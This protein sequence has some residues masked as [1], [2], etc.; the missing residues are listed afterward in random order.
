MDCVGQELMGIGV[1]SLAAFLFALV[2]GSSA[3]AACTLPY[4]FIDNTIAYSAQIDAN[5]AAVADCTGGGGAVGGNPT[6]T[7]SDVAVNGAAA[8]FMRSDA[9]PAIQKASAS[10]FGIVEVDGTTITSSGGVITAT[11]GGSGCTISGAAG[12]VFNTGS[13]TCTTDAAITAT[14]GALSLGSSGTA[15]S[16]AFGNATS[17]TITLQ[18]VT[19]A[20]GSSVLSL[21]IAT[22]TLVGKATIDTLTNKT[23]TSPTMTAPVLGTPASGVATNLTGTAAGLTAGTVT[24]NANLTGPI[25]STGNA[26]AI[27]SQTG[28]GTKFVVDTSPTLVTPILGIATA[29]SVNKVALTAPATSATLTIADGKTLTDTSGTGAVALK[30]AT[31]GGFAQ[32]ACADLSNGATGCSTTVGTMATQAASAVAI[33]GGTAAGLTGL[34]IRD[35]SAAFDVTIAGTSSTALSAG[36]VLTLDMKNVAHTLAF[37]STANTITFPSA[38]SYT[39]FGTND[40]SGN[41]TTAV[42]TT[43]T[44]T[45]GDCV[46]IDANGNHIANGSACGSGGGT[47]LAITVQTFSASGTYTPAAGLIYAIAECVGDGGGGGG[48]AANATGNS[49]GGGG[50]AGSYS[51]VRLTAAQI[52]ASQA[53]TIPTAAAGGATGNNAGANGGDVSL[54]TLCVGKGGVGGGGNAGSGAQGSGGAG[55]VAGTGDLASVG[56]S[57][58]GSVGSSITTLS[59][60]SGAGGSTLWGGGGGSIGGSGAAADGVAPGATA[61]GAG[62]S[63]GLS[64]GSASTAA[65]G[66]GAKGYVLITEYAGGTGGTVTSIATTSPITGGTISTTGTIACATCATTTNGGA[67]SGTAPVAISVGGAISITGAA[68]QVLAGVGPAFTATPTFGGSGT[69]GTLAL[70]NATSGTVTL[71]TVTGALGSVTASLPA[72]TGTIAELNLAQTWTAAQTFGAV[73]GGIITD[74]TTTRTLGAGDCGQTINFT[75][76]SAITVTTANLAV[77]CHIVVRQA[78][79]GQITI[80]AGGGTTIVSASSWTKTRAQYSKLG[81]SII[82]TTVTDIDGDGA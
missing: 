28:T 44:Q 29:T 25:T 12:A 63:G 1:R 76:G 71:G 30:G 61:Y 69:V 17:G 66:A 49:G 19:G 78:G 32:A 52:G 10:V 75:S 4:T 45:N 46:K 31:G 72:N 3:E 55:G 9:A 5:F 7:A 39:L 65:G 34:A 47:P 41:T 2:I 11:T 68:G 79:A 26:T 22:D 73:F 60:L 67:L 50:G 48:A 58:A 6:A 81:L 33:T 53:V 64:A 14:A 80:A 21:P 36:R 37:G 62:G 59:G 51:L 56:Q 54:G 27:A 40:R 70:G 24:T 57:G 16:V 74:S 35:T 8:T 43:G 20:L 82:A 13:S 18:P 38:A 23:L 77:G 15:G 42:T